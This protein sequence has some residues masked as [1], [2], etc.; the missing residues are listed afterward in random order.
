[1]NRSAGVLMPIFSLCGEY[2]IGTF[3]K[4]AY[5]FVDFLYRSKQKYWQLLPLSPTTKG[6]SPYSS[7]CTYAGNPLLIDFDL[8]REDGLID[9]NE[10]SDIDF[11]KDE[12]RVD[13]DILN[14]KKNHI[15]KL[16]ASKF[17]DY[18]C[19]DRCKDK[20]EYDDFV[21]DNRFFIDDYAIYQVLKE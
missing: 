20:D 19:E 14:D 6:N 1:M 13:Y 7:P 12:G 4:E 15:L 18:M 16:A 11:G 17:Y 10:Y 3:G 9:I 2:G 21:K 8:L 5:N